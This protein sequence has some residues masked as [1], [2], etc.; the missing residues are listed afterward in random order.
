[1]L[2]TVIK[3]NIKGQEAVRAELEC[4]NFEQFVNFTVGMGVDNE[5]EEMV[6]DFMEGFDRTYIIPLEKFDV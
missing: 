3:K 1:M 4:G 5:F 2:I 6:Q